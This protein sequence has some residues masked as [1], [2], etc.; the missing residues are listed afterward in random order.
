M[1]LLLLGIV[2]FLKREPSRVIVQGGKA[3]A[4]CASCFIVVFM[5]QQII[6]ALG[7]SVTL[8]VVGLVTIPAALPAWLPI[9]LFAP[10]CALLLDSVKT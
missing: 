2:F 8:P 1:L 7:S 10:L 5:A 3:L 6:G 9:I 4:V